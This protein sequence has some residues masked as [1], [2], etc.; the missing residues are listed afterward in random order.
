MLLATLMPVLPYALELL[1]LREMTQH[2]FGTLMALEPAIA[3]ILGL[4]VLGQSPAIIEVI[5][6]M[7]VVIAGAAAQRGGVRQPVVA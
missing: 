4:I 6:I 2:A 5:G 7:I 1:A 3:I